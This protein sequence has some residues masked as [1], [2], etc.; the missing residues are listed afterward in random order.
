M[1]IIGTL[2]SFS[3]NDSFFLIDEKDGFK[4]MY[5]DPNWLFITWEINPKKI[6]SSTDIKK[7]KKEKKKGDFKLIDEYGVNG[8]FVESQAFA[9]LAIRSYLGEPIS[10]PETT[11]VT[12]PCSGGV[13]IKI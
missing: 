11:G 10:F 3:I 12:K 8:D 13:I 7:V 9:Y 5:M 6:T 2:L 1:L 4:L